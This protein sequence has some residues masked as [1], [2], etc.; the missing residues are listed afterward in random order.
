MVAGLTTYAG[1]KW[2]RDQGQAVGLAL[3]QGKPGAPVQTAEEAVL[4]SVD[5][6]FSYQL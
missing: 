4:R 5:F 2:I 6:M 1:D 3:R